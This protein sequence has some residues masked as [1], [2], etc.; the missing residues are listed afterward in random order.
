MKASPSPSTGNPD[1][2]DRAH[3]A[4]LAAS[5]VAHDPA[6]LAEA[7][8][9]YS[10]SLFDFARSIVR[11]QVLAEDVV[12]DVFLRLWNQAERFDPTRG[13]LRSYVLTLGYGRSIDVTRSES[14]RRKREEREGVLTGAPVDAGGAEDALADR[15]AVH[16]ALDAL[17][18]TEREAI[19][20][21]YFG[22]HS[23]REVAAILGAPEGTVKNRIRAGLAH[24]RT[25]LAD[26][27]M[28]NPGL[29]DTEQ[30]GGV[31]SP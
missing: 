28:A 11:D 10:H 16:Q 31:L 13:S 22:D 20:L 30:P 19:A 27:G 25:Q 4:A 26:P 2:S 18:P 17:Q 7:Y 24:L 3:D 21:A 9:E 29:F 5:I 6:A 8:R 1:G 14:A 23:Y 12:Q 15:D